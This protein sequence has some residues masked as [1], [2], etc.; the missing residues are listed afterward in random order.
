[1]HGDMHLNF[2]EAIVVTVITV[3]LCLDNYDIHLP[4]YFCVFTNVCVNLNLLLSRICCTFVLAYPTSNYR[5]RCT[6][7]NSE[8]N[9]A[10]PHTSKSVQIRF[11]LYYPIM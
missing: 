6:E 7:G 2:I 4:L 8:S 5:G 10:W 1:M 11:N 9:R 3:H